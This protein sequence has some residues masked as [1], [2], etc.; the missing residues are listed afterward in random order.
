[1]TEIEK[2]LEEFKRDE[3]ERGGR[4]AD[5]QTAI[6]AWVCDEAFDIATYDT[7][8]SIAFGR[9]ILDVMSAILGKRTFNYIKLPGKYHAYIAVCHILDQRDMID[10][11]SSI[12]GAW[13][14]YDAGCGKR[15]MLGDIP[16]TEENVR[17]I[18]RIYEQSENRGDVE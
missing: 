2:R 6:A 14:D 7:D 12:R 3:I 9:A 8:V 10:W 4:Y 15:K 5:D 11:G 1:M 17:E 16:F 18:L 13:F